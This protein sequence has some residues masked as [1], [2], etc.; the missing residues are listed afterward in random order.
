MVSKK[1]LSQLTVWL[2]H[3]KMDKLRKMADVKH[4]PMARLI[5][6]ALDTYIDMGGNFEFDFSFP[7]EEYV[8]YA[9]ADQAGKIVTYM[10]KLRLGM[11]LDSLL[12]CRY[13]IGIPDKKIFLLAFKECLEKKVVE[14]FPPPDNGFNKRPYKPDYFYYRLTGYTTGR[15]K[16]MKAKKYQ[17]Y[18]RLKKQ[19]GGID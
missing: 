12:L 13:D 3:D 19:F 1:L 18:L 2:S 5:S 11:G 17:T 8:E 7:D 15:S 6:Y 4:V 14:A 16:K 9:Y 10:G